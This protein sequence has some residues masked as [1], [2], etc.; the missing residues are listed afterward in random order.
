[1]SFLPEIEWDIFDILGEGERL[2][3]AKREAS[4]INHSKAQK[5][6]IAQM[7]SS[8]VEDEG[9]AEKVTEHTQTPPQ[10]TESMGVESNPASSKDEGEAEKANEHPRMPPGLQPM[11][12]TEVESKPALDNIYLK[13]LQLYKKMSQLMEVV[14]HTGEGQGLDERFDLIKDE[15][16]A[17]KATEHT[18]TPPGLEVTSKPVSMKDEEVAEHIWQSWLGQSFSGLGDAKG[19]P[20]RRAK[21]PPKIQL[22]ESKKVESKPPSIKDERS[23]EKVSEH[24]YIY[25]R[26]SPKTWPTKSNKVGRRVWISGAKLRSS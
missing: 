1:M 21:M 22:T 4:W 19:R 3:A 17:E 23:A 26:V 2:L 18:R 9:E 13:E 15:R 12:K 8:E 10:L 11:E 7:E 6:Q 16:P 24:I 20:T 25:T 14:R 5:A